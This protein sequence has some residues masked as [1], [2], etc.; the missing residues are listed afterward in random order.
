M[1]TLY[2]LDVRKAARNAIVTLLQSK[3]APIKFDI[4]TS[5]N[6]VLV[7]LP[8]MN[9]CATVD[10]GTGVLTFHPVSGSVNA[11][12]AGTAA[13]AVL[14]DAG[15]AIDWITIDVKAG[16]AVDVGYFVLSMVDIVVGSPVQIVSA[17]VG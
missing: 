1:A 5:G 3:T 7:S 17:T 10:S 15:G 8:L 12:G 2:H 11:T 6:A 13:K 16:S 14:R 9:P 4:L